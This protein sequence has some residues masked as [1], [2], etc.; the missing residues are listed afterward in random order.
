MRARFKHT[1]GQRDFWFAVCLLALALVSVGLWN[2]NRKLIVE[3][4][5]AQARSDAALVQLCDATTALDLSV[6]VPLLT[7]TRNAI[8][9]LPLGPE[10]ER[11]LRIESN[12]TVAHQE[13]SSQTQCDRVR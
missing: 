5:Q 12:L 10:L 9:E 4:Q 13:L 6:V 2:Q 1:L 11:A 7:E 8:S 3:H